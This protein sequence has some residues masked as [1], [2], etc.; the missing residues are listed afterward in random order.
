MANGIY[1]TDNKAIIGAGPTKSVRI[2]NPEANKDVHTIVAVNNGNVGGLFATVLHSYDPSGIYKYKL[3]FLPNTNFNNSL[4]FADLPGGNGDVIE[5]KKTTQPVETGRFWHLLYKNVRDSDP[6]IFTVNDIT[7]IQG[8]ST[9]AVRTTSGGVPQDVLAAFYNNKKNV[10]LIKD[11][12]TVET[13]SKQMLKNIT[14]YTGKHFKTSFFVAKDTKINGVTKT[15]PG[16]YTIQI[17]IANSDEKYLFTQAHANHSHNTTYTS[18]AL[19]PEYTNLGSTQ[20]NSSLLESPAPGGAGATKE[21][22]KRYGDARLDLFFHS[23]WMKVIAN[24]SYSDVLDARMRVSLIP[25]LIEFMRDINATV[26]NTAADEKEALAKEQSRV[27]GDYLTNK[28]KRQTT[29]TE[30]KSFSGNNTKEVILSRQEDLDIY[31]DYIKPPPAIYEYIPVG[32][33]YG[34]NTYLVLYGNYEGGVV[35]RHPIF[36][37]SQGYA[38]EYRIDYRK[39]RTVV[40]RKR[41]EDKKVTFHDTQYIDDDRRKGWSKAYKLW[42]AAE[43]PAYTEGRNVG[44][45]YPGY[46]WEVTR[47]YETQYS[48]KEFPERG[49]LP[50][51]VA[52]SHRLYWWLAGTHKDIAD[53]ISSGYYSV[54]QAEVFRILNENFSPSRNFV[55]MPLRTYQITKKEKYNKLDVQ[56][57]SITGNEA[58]YPTRRFVTRDNSDNVYIVDEKTNSQTVILKVV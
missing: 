42:Y 25:S 10:L 23:T 52:F 27:Q 2:P 40:G 3:Y 56:V 16:R 39:E 47:Q 51:F 29:Q 8:K 57:F 20:P 43:R 34:Q 6:E 53:K 37:K 22:R 12:L 15:T 35:E 30:R 48:Y 46:G 28:I 54:G 49:Y 14:E 31:V 44:D 18:G 7:K 32:N 17:K 11:I 55:K 36:D 5:F 26:A 13:T 4:I 9:T 58:S 19:V 33:K 38:G 24:E 1:T 21:S 50:N 41:V 45:R